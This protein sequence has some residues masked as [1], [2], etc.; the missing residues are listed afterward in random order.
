MTFVTRTAPPIC[1]P[2]NLLSPL[3]CIYV[4]SLFENVKCCRKKYGVKL[5]FYS[6]KIF[7]ISPWSFDCFFCTTFS[8]NFTRKCLVAHLDQFSLPSILS[9][10]VNLALLFFQNVISGAIVCNCSNSLFFNS[11]LRSFSDPSGHKE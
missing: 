6:Y 11:S 5:T 10:Y 9:Q 8:Y 7:D 3:F 2:H 1:T 4:I